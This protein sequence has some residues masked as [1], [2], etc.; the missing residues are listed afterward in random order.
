MSI[1]IDKL[2]AA[3]TEAQRF[4]RLAERAK[5][6]Y[7]AFSSEASKHHAAAKRASMDL[8]RALAEFRGRAS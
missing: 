6:D 2:D 3:M 5:A 8:T 1:E 7:R 4:L